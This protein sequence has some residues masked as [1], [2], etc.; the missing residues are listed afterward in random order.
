[1]KRKL[2]SALIMTLAISSL[3]GC[4][5][6]EKTT[7][8]SLIADGL[9]TLANAE[10]S[11][12]DLS[13]D[14]AIKAKIDETMSM[15]MGVAFSG[16]MEIEGD[17]TY[18]DLD[19]NISVMGMSLEES[20]EMWT[21]T[22][23]DT[24]YTYTKVGS[25]GEW[26]VEES[27]GVESEGTEKV[28]IT[29]DE[30]TDIFSNI[31]LHDR[32]KGENYVV[33][34]NLDMDDLVELLEDIS[35]KDKEDAEEVLDILEEMGVDSDVDLTFDIDMIFDGGSKDLEMLNLDI[36]G[37][38][39]NDEEIEFTKLEVRMKFKSFNEELDLAVPKKVKDNAVEESSSDI[40]EGFG[41]DD[42]IVEDDFENILTPEVE[43]EVTPDVEPETEP[44]DTPD[45][46][47]SN[48][49]WIDFNDIHFYVNGY[50]VTLGKTTLQ[51][52]I[53]AGV[54]FEE[55]DLANANNNIKPNYES[56]TFSIPLGEYWSANVSFGNY[57][58]NNISTKDA[59]IC[60][61]GYYTRD[62]EKQNIVTFDFPD[63]MDIDTLL[64][65]AGE[66]TETR[67][68]DE[69]PKYVSKYFVYEQ[70]ST[71]YYGNFGYEFYFMNG[72]LDSITLDY[73]P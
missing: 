51:D 69:D 44:T 8:E 68:Y 57:T 2:A 66:P 26:T 64:A 40:F 54:P 16:D 48:G 72:N 52:M 45:V 12:L 15:D 38:T 59:V 56:D 32:E 17:I 63:T 4:S 22:K 62:D 28:K 13:I 65:N 36:S 29:E 61:L 47:V 39:L 25:D 6:F 71:M 60:Y 49:E 27:D 14:M 67:V 55:E 7:A 42:E 5:L 34:A 20:M 70:D 30:V 50:K 33:S 1:M 23:G 18:G 53:D 41:F 46:I 10:S 21:E 9:T 43:P 11:E 37:D 35:G 31:K 58:E 73:L 24:Q 19:F 3:T